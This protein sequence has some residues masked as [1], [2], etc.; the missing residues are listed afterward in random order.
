MG[1]GDCMKK[2]HM[3]TEHANSKEISL[4]PLSLSLFV[5]ETSEKRIE[6]QAENNREMMIQGVDIFHNIPTQREE[7]KR[8]VEQVLCR[9]SS[10][11]PVGLL[12]CDA[13]KDLLSSLA[14]LQNSS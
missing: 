11:Y 6:W 1:Y 2:E 9:C 3:L 10:L 7:K 13:R 5:N 8:N 14:S 4:S 12:L